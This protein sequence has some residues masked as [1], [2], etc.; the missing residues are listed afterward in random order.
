VTGAVVLACLAGCASVATTAKLDVSVSAQTSFVFTDARPADEATTSHR[1]SS[2]G[3]FTKMGDD[4]L[5][6]S[7]AELVK[8]WLQ[9]ELAGPLA[10]RDV[11][12][13]S[14]VLEV[15]DPN[16]AVDQ[17]RLSQAAAGV[18]GAGPLTMLGAG[19]LIRQFERARGARSVSVTVELALDGVPIK[20]QSGAMV[21]GGLSE[22]DITAT[23]RQALDS[24]VKETS[25]VGAVRASTLDGPKRPDC[26]G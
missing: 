10:G 11:R 20:V 3:V 19:L 12:L 2:V 1:P 22:Q 17:G 26:T 8:T 6:P 18:P 5:H 9:R 23:V 16:G 13:R 14:F 25:C 21:L 15:F 7:G 4:R 24:L